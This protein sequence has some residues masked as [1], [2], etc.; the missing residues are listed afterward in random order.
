MGD[1]YDV[2]V[3]GT[4]CPGAPLAAHLARAGRSVAVV[5]R[6]GGW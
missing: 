5:D 6:D 2:V 1:S 3:V 4:G